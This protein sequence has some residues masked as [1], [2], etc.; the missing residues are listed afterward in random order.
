MAH[1]YDEGK[2]LDAVSNGRTKASVRLAPLDAVGVAGGKASVLDKVAM[3]RPARP[4]IPQDAFSVKDYMARFGLSNTSADRELN[5]MVE[6]G[7]LATA[8][9]L[10]YDRAPG[11]GHQARMYWPA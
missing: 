9:G 7:I 5:D 3:L 1:H 4:V 11:A 6:R 8:I 10:A 2:P